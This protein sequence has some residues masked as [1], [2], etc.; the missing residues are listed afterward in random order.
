MNKILLAVS[1]GQRFASHIDFA[2]AHDSHGDEYSPPPP[3]PPRSRSP[4]IWGGRRCG[5]LFDYGVVNV[6]SEAN[7][8][9]NVVAP[10]VV[11]RVRLAPD[12]RLR[13]AMKSETGGGAGE[14]T[15]SAPRVNRSWSA[16]FLPTGYLWTLFIKQRTKRG[17]VK[18]MLCGP[19]SDQS[20]GDILTRR[21]P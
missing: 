8:E 9:A 21:I 18:I 10:R 7:R 17:F 1:G 5:A 12:G 4:W 16:S 15:S 2:R 20:S 19:E 14:T 3:P 13:R 6:P 11:A